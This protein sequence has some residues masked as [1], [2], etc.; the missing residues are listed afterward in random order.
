MT[1]LVF[2]IG[3]L[4]M[5]CHAPV[6]R[7]DR[8]KSPPVVL[9]ARDIGTERVGPFFYGMGIEEAAQLCGKDLSPEEK[10]PQRRPG[11]LGKERPST[12]FVHC[13][14][15]WENKSPVLVSLLFE[16]ARLEYVEISLDT[17]VTAGLSTRDAWIRSAD[18][19]LVA[20]RSMSSIPLETK[21]HWQVDGED[22]KEP[23]LVRD[24][25]TGTILLDQYIKLAPTYLE[26]GDYAHFLNFFIGW[27]GISLSVEEDGVTLQF[28]F[29]GAEAKKQK[30]TKQASV[31]SSPEEMDVDPPPDPDA[32]PA[33][34]ANAL[35]EASRLV[36]LPFPEWKDLPLGTPKKGV[37]QWVR[38]QRLRGC[39]GLEEEEPAGGGNASVASRTKSIECPGVRFAQG[40]SI[41]TFYFNFDFLYS[42]D[43]ILQPP[44]RFLAT[45]AQARPH[46]ARLLHYTKRFFGDTVYDEGFVPEKSQGDI[47]AIDKELHFDAAKRYAGVT[48]RPK[49]KSP[50]YEASARIRREA[51]GVFLASYFVE[52]SVS[53]KS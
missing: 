31:D 25:L 48:W 43:V 22:I 28:N 18:F 34:D 39:V 3:I 11:V 9:S 23:T 27:P 26:G 1:W 42:I 17:A 7:P 46:L 52:W 24:A 5:A 37:V 8:V 38:K 44:G 33:P 30:K 45:F 21:W 35:K 36:P 12:A 47:G 51:T 20:L 16:K 29:S 49:K 6:R 19:W 14:A 40:S 50:D 32:Q 13:H 10:A 41:V 2:C 4:L 53:R 15:W